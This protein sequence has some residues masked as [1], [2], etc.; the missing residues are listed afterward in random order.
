MPV[1]T[2]VI[3][4][5]RGLWEELY[6]PEVVR[7][8]GITLRHFFINTFGPKSKSEITTIRYPE[9]KPVL[10][11]RYRG[12]HRLMHRDDGSVRCTACM[13]CATVCPANCIH[14]EADERENPSSRDIEKYPKVFEIDE[15]VCVVCGLCVEACPCDAL[16]MDSQVHM[17]PVT[18]RS[19]AVMEKDQLMRRGKQSIATDGGAGPAWRSK[20]DFLGSLTQ[21]YRP[22]HI[23]RPDQD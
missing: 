23:Y 12:V 2:K 3:E 8:L 16:R 13:M 20:F 1:K 19:E 9:E 22:E 10:P 5:R 14:I 7:G 17:P 21:I 6:V 15:L 11:E 4:A 18:R